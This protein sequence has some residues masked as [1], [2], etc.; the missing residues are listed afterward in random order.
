[1]LKLED[2]LDSKG[3]VLSD[4]KME[5]LHLKRLKTVIVPFEFKKGTKALDEYAGLRKGERCDGPISRRVLL[6]REGTCGT[7]PVRQ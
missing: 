3:K 7:G 5:L 1:V 4:T 6:V 2:K